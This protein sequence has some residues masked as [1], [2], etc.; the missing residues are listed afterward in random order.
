MD[1]Y[2]G[3]LLEQK[4]L[5]NAV[6]SLPNT[7]FKEEIYWRDKAIYAVIQYCKV[8]KGG[9]YLITFKLCK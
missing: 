8:E 1:P 6:I 9:I 3:I 7:I 2:K 4:E 5:V